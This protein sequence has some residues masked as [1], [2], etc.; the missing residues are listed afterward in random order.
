[1]SQ[2][3]SALDRVGERHCLF[4]WGFARKHK[5]GHVVVDRVTEAT[6]AVNDTGLP[7][8]HGQHLAD[9]AGLEAR[10]HQEKVAT[11]V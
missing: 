2:T 5:P 6:N 8:P 1:M 4:F 3:Q 7:G 10:R 11:V 9:A